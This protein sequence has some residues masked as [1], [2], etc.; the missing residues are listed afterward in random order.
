MKPGR[1]NY[2]IHACVMIQEH[3]KALTMIYQK[4]SL[5]DPVAGK[6]SFGLE[7]WKVSHIGSPRSFATRVSRG[8]DV[9]GASFL[10][11]LS[12]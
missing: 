11:N 1:N 8:G 9:D 7:E 4:Y 12:V 10:R 6:P 3:Q 5:L 2:L